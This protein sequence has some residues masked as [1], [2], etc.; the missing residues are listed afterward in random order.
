MSIDILLASFNGGK[1]IE[2][3]MLS[4]ISQS[5]KDWRLLVHDDG[6]SDNTVEIVKRLALIDGRIQ[7]IEDGVRC[8]SPAKNFMHLLKYSDAD[9]VMFCDQDDIWFDNKVEVMYRAIQRMD[10]SKP[11]VAYS[12]SYAWY[13]NAGIKGL[14]TLTFPTSLKSFLFLNSGMQG[15]V[16]IFNKAMKTY[17]L[18]YTAELAMHDHLIHFLGIAVGEVHYEPVP[19]MLYRNHEH[20]VTGG[21]RVRI[22]DFSAITQGLRVPVVDRKHY[23]AIAN[24]S[25]TYAE[26][27]SVENKQLINTYLKMPA[28]SLFSRIYLIFKHGYKLFDSRLWL[29][30]KVFCKPY[31]N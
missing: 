26:H 7:L 3:Q 11:V 30:L 24:F 2:T 10:S 9:F 27:L 29:V 28:L 17:C 22:L 12:N 15:C 13:P 18:R 8:G 14:S 16:S 19:L 6:S 20:N 1:Y 31:I 21:T 4:I 23:E 25:K 5:Y